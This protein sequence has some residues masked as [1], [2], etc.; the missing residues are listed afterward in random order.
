[1]I[2]VHLVGNTTDFVNKINRNEDGTYSFEKISK[3]GRRAHGIYPSGSVI[4][5]EV[6]DEKVETI[7]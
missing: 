6:W 2:V 5:Y 3:E 7:V 4:S 1:M